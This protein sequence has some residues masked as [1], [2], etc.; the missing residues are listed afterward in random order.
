MTRSR[1]AVRDQSSEQLFRRLVLPYDDPL[2]LADQMSSPVVHRLSPL[3]NQ[4]RT[5]VPPT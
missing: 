2:T 3:P 1:C 4:F 5:P